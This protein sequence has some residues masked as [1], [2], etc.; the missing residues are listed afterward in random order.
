[1]QQVFSPFCV[2]ITP[3]GNLTPTYMSPPPSMPFFMN[4]FGQSCINNFGFFL[5]P[6][7]PNQPGGGQGNN[8]N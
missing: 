2:A 3:T 7:N 8:V 1:M 5:N 4:N 6:S